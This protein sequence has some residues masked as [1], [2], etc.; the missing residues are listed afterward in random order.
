MDPRTFQLREQTR[1]HFFSECGVGLGSIALGAMLHGQPA[2][3]ADS[4]N[5]MAPKQGHFPGRARNVIFLFM[6][7][8]PSQ[9]ELFDHKPKLQELDGQPIPASY[10]ENK[11]FAFLKK[12][13]ALLGTNRKFRRWGESGAEISDLL[14]HLGK[15]ADDISMSLIHI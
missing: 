9:L 1:R 12:D 13:Q 7:G 3:A 6:A 8:G 2:G 14:P 5:P 4:V 11:R 15:I 10:I